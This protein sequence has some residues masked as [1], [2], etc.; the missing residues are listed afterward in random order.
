MLFGKPKKL[1]I[2]PKSE[3]VEVYTDKETNNFSSFPLSLYKENAPVD[4]LPLNEYLKAEKPGHVIVL[5][6]EDVMVTKSF[7]YDTKSTTIDKQEVLKLAQDTVGFEIDQ[8]NVEFALNQTGPKTIIQSDLFHSTKFKLLESNL[9]KLA[10]LPDKVE[11]LSYARAIA[12]VINN[13]Y[14]QEYFSI[15]TYN[16]DEHVLF[17]A[18]GDNLFLTN[19]LKGTHPEIQKIINYSNLYFDKTINRLFHP[20]NTILEYKVQAGLEKAEFEESSIATQLKFAPN[21]PVPA[22]GAFMPGESKTK[23]IS[24]PVQT[25][26]VEAPSP[27]ILTPKP[28]VI[29]P[30]PQVA[31]LSLSSLSTPSVADTTFLPADKKNSTK[32]SRSP[33]PIFLAILATALLVSGLVWYVYNRDSSTADDAPT[34]TSSPQVT[35]TA[36][37]TPKPTLAPVNKALKIQVLNATDISGQAASIKEQLLKLGFKTVTTGNASAKSTENL[38]RV[39]KKYAEMEEFFVQE[40]ASF[41]ATFQATLPETNASDIIITIGTD[42]SGST[43]NPTTTT[44][45]KKAAAP[46][47][48]GDGTVEEVQ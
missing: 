13:F 23:A 4:L 14:K 34:P 42:L 30:Q 16:K 15:Y 33:L 9:V 32:G 1:V 48:A 5:L 36:E 31:P 39:K 2:I 37:P 35:P 40:M 3:T 47:P 11:Y 43:T 6:T 8:D 17:L 28:E 20:K 38:I 25:A 7:V 24:R 46:T 10:N 29:T 27:V 22:V 44:T 12:R 45:T 26:K 41:P 19:K 18:K 21:L